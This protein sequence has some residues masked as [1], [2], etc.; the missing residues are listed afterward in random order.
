MAEERPFFERRAHRISIKCQ[1]QIELEIIQKYFASANPLE[2]R[3][4]LFRERL[5]E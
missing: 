4:G 2:G 5:L 1:I 3:R